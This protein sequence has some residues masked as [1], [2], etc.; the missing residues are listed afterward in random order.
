MPEKSQRD[1]ADNCNPTTE[2]IALTKIV[3]CLLPQLL[4]WV[5]CYKFH[6]QIK[7]RLSSPA[8]GKNYQPTK[9]SRSQ[10]V[11]LLQQG[12][13]AQNLTALDW[14]QAFDGSLLTFP[15]PYGRGT[16]NLDSEPSRDRKEAET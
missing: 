5:S 7:M 9:R 1:L 3:Q 4:Q 16:A 8:R 6:F 12:I 10:Q 13:D 11:S 2:N 14:Y 15:L